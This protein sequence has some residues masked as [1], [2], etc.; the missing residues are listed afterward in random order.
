MADTD[1]GSSVEAA[2]H[3]LEESALASLGNEPAETTEATP[4]SEAPEAVEAVAETPSDESETAVAEEK[5]AFSSK[6]LAKFNGD[7]QKLDDD[8]FRIQN[9]SAEL[10]RKI[11]NLE[12][13]LKEAKGGAKPVAEEQ[14]QAA[15]P[16]AVEISPELREIGDQVVMLNDVVKYIESQGLPEA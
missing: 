11:A 7:Q 12:K 6:A 1:H 10:S 4:A 3:S 9:R 15:S 14:S 2:I 13:E 5:P 8:Y 16:A